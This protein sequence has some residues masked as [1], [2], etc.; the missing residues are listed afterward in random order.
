MSVPS[1]LRPYRGPGGLWTESPELNAMATLA[2]AQ[3][4]NFVRSAEYAGARAVFVNL[5]PLDPPNP[6]FH[7][8]HL[9]PAEHLLP[10]LFGV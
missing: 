9:G 2:A 5:K 10:T 3:A 6:A 1:W 4:D 7:E 8:T